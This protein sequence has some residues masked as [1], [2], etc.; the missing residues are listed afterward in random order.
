MPTF[1]PTSDW[2]AT[3][4]HTRFL[5]P[6]RFTPALL[7][8][9]G[10]PAIEMLE[11]L[12]RGERFQGKPLWEEP[13]LTEMHD[14]GPVVHEFYR[15]DLQPAVMRFLF[16]RNSP[17][18]GRYFRLTNGAVNR[19]FPN[20]TRIVW[21]HTSTAPT[22]LHPRV[23]IELF[24][25][26]HGVGI[27][28]FAMAPRDEHPWEL[29]A[30][31]DFNYRMAQRRRSLAPVLQLPHP[32]E[33]A[34]W[35][36]LDP[37]IRAKAPVAPARDAKF[38]SRFGHPGGSFTLE[39][40]SSYLLKPFATA[41]CADTQAQFGVFT[42]VRFDSDVFFADPL[43]CRQLAPFLSGLA[44]IEE[45]GHAG[46][47]PDEVTV[48]HAVLNTRHWSAAGCQAGAH[49][50]ADQGIEFDRQRP[51]VVRDKYFVPFLLAQLQGL[52]LEQAVLHAAKLA[53]RLQ[54]DGASCNVAG[55]DGSNACA[56]D[57]AALRREF[58][59][60][61]GVCH[62]PQVSDRA[63][64]NRWYEV[65]R[66]GLGIPRAHAQLSTTIREIDSLCRFAAELQN[67]Q[68]LI[69]LTDLQRAQQEQLAALAK[70]MARNVSAITAMQSK[71]EYVEIFLIAVY[72][73]YLIFHLGET[74]SFQH[75]YTGISLL[76]GSVTAAGLAACALRPW[77]HSHS[78][79]RRKGFT[80]LLLVVVVLLLGAFIGIGH[81][82][83]HVA[84]T[85][86][87]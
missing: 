12:L 37:A 24:L 45:S 55:A 59:E 67:Q 32:S 20:G 25:A 18:T 56:G 52:F 65:A 68:K 39:E 71:V 30:I 21:Q 72:A 4:F 8:H 74:L 78:G 62:V 64:L 11:T 42:V 84:E 63:A 57:F 22:W 9:N 83:F 79:G 29:N 38:D 76:I 35:E 16:E 28:S 46:S 82:F 58:L 43:V 70:E 77:H 53:P 5:Y 13:A 26:A 34:D 1:P 69:D 66:E 3:E 2:P 86:T 15:Q 54:S 44:Q 7:A 19:F 73:N 10:K 41:E 75:T 61:D 80:I 6:F 87:P 17:R 27:L 49:L 85:A 50:I 81:R 14:G 60:F 31:K 23:E 47:R 40:I 33:R 51:G 36:T 48:S